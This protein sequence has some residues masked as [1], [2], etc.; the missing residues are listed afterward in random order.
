M[1][2]GFQ[3]KTLS[4]TMF[5]ENILD[6]EDKYRDNKSGQKLKFQE[7]SNLVLDFN[8]DPCSNLL[9]EGVPPT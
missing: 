5:K 8:I 4:I 2:E 9:L 3:N 6:N 1:K 7:N